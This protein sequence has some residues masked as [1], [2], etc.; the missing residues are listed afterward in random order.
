MG[1]I[2]VSL[3][4]VGAVDVRLQTWA[5]LIVA[6]LLVVVARGGKED[7]AAQVTAVSTTTRLS[8]ASNGTEANNLS[9]APSVSAAS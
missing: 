5:L 6:F 8:E 2:W 9:L 4:L 7:V 1:P 3:A